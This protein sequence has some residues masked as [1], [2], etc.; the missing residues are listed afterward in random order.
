MLLQLL[1][2]AD[3]TAEAF[4]EN[5]I[6]RVIVLDHDLE[7]AGIISSLDI[8]RETSL[9]GKAWP[10]FRQ[11]AWPSGDATQPFRMVLF[12]RLERKDGPIH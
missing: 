6:Q 1:R 7:F 3:E 2:R 9:D 11:T 12:C 4:D 5:M 8:A 10:W